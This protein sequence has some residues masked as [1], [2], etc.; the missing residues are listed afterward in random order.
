MAKK[1]MLDLTLRSQR[2]EQ[3]ARGRNVWVVEESRR[4]VPAAKSVLLLCDVWDDHSHRGAAER[5]AAMAPRMNEVVKS[6]RTRG[7]R[8]VHAPSDCMDFYAKHPARKRMLAIPKLELPTMK[9]RPDPPL[10]FDAQSG[11]DTNETAGYK[12][13]SR[14]HPAI[15][16]ADEDAITE[17]GR[18]LY[19]FMR[20]HDL[21]HFF[22]MGV[23][24]NMC[25][26]HRTFGIKALVKWG[27]DCFL[28]RD[29]TDCIY[30][31]AMPPY[32]SHDEGTQLVIGYIEKFWCPSIHSREL[33]GR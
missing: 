15:K 13:W 20:R 30:N 16:I 24:T 2:L 12:A 26:L 4:Q 6:A 18:E 1:D 28:L 3:D 22:I 7:V 9:L 5:V 11:S 10:P 32:V 27:F 29:L 23:H 17:S 25:V 31:P 14:Q 33:A 21:A 8:V 19:A